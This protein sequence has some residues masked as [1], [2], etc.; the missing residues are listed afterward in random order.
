LSTDS[1]RRCAQKGQGS[2]LIVF[3]NPYSDK[4]F[5]DKFRVLTDRELGIPSLCFKASKINTNSTGN[6]FIGF[7]ANNAVKINLRLGNT[8]DIQPFL[9][10]PLISH[11]LAETIITGPDVSHPGTDST[12]GTGSIASLVGTVDDACSIYQGSA[13]PNT[14]RREVSS[15]FPWAFIAHILTFPDD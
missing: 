4:K 6:R 3:I 8:T 2:Q 9:N 13:R 5:Y 1:I 15:S 7:V 12:L 14:P 11:K 10:G